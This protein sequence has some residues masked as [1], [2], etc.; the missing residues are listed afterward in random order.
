MFLMLIFFIFFLL[1]RIEFFLK[2][3]EYVKKIIVE[4]KFI[5]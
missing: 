3:N 2:V 4:M 1:E 5:K